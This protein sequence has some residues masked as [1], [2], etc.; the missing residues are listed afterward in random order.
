MRITLSLLLLAG[1]MTDPNGE[2]CAWSPGNDGFCPSGG[3]GSSS[4]EKVTTY[5]SPTGVGLSDHVR[6]AMTRTHTGEKP[7]IESTAVVPGQEPN[8]AP[9]LLDGETPLVGSIGPQLAAIDDQV[10]LVWTQAGGTFGAPLAPGATVRSD[11]ILD[12]E[13]RYGT[14]L[15]VAQRFLFVRPR[16]ANGTVHGLWIGVDGR[17]QGTIELATGVAFETLF[18]IN[19]DTGMI[20]IAYLAKVEAKPA[21]LRFAR[22]AA[23]GTRIDNLVIPIDGYVV[24]AEVVP[25]ADGGVL[26]V[27]RTTTMVFVARVSSHGDVLVSAA[28]LPRVTQLVRGAAGNFALTVFDGGRDAYKEGRVLDD[29]GKIIGGPFGLGLG[30]GGYAFATPDGFALVHATRDAAIATTTL[31]GSGPGPTIEVAYTTV[32]DGCGCRTANSSTAGLLLL[33][34]LLVLRRRPCRSRSSALVS[35]DS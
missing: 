29:D 33:A 31:N 2:T 1:C 5:I 34:G 4:N 10:Y 3:G 26:G 11:E 6:V 30:I 7:Q 23:D 19:A 12:L 27:V 8:V 9:I 28:N 17:S 25:T 24:E 20:A 15:R 13:A 16:D 18:D 32:D 35:S 22:I 14:L 21:E